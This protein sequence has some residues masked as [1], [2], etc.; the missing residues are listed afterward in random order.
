MDKTKIMQ[1]I[2]L[3]LEGLGIEDWE[4]DQH[5]KETPERA[6]RGFMEVFKGYEENPRELLSK[7]FEEKQYDQMLTIGPIT[8]WSMCSH[9]MLPFSMKVYVGYIPNGKIVGISKFVRVV[10]A[11]SAR[12]QVQERITEEIAD[13]VNEVLE[14]LGCI[15]L[16]KDSKHMCMTMRGVKDVNASVSTSAIRGNFQE[17]KVKQ[18]FFDMIR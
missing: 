3:F 6:A 9:H 11:I 2:E 10:R 13:V 17:N 5:L 18:E 1:G 14:P 16:I 7:F 12:L 15:V 4:A 8:T